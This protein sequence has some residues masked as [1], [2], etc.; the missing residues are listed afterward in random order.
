MVY[1]SSITDNG[2]SLSSARVLI[3]TCIWQFIH[4]WVYLD[5]GGRDYDVYAKEISRDMY[6]VTCFNNTILELAD[7]HRNKNILVS[8]KDQESDDDKR[9]VNRDESINDKALM[10]DDFSNKK[11]CA[12]GVLKGLSGGLM[13]ANDEGSVTKTMILHDERRTKEIVEE[14]M[15]EQ[16]KEKKR[17][18]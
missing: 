11:G 5:V 2:E 13:M 17:T 15:V 10:D 3:N 7:T 8:I 1:L 18:R 4:G 9:E 6:N 12:Q 14:L 16:L